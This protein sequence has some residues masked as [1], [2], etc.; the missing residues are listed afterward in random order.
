MYLIT[1]Q[2]DDKTNKK[3]QSWIDK[4]ASATGNHFMSDDQAWKAAGFNNDS[5]DYFDVPITVAFRDLYPQYIKT[6]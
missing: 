3:I 2:F 1:A 4:I 6:N 5:N